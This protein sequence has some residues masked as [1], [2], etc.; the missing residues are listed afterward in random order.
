MA[1]PTTL[2]TAPTANASAVATGA[3]RTT[4][5][6]LDIITLERCG[7]SVKVVSPVRWL[8]SA[9]TES[10]AIMGRITDSGKPVAKVKVL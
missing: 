1:V 2:P 3:T 4:A 6:A 8:H 7:T 9:V 10:T 5:R